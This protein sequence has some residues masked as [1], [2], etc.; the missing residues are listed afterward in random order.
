[1]KLGFILIFITTTIYSF[2]LQVDTIKDHEVKN[3]FVNND[4]TSVKIDSV[5]VLLLRSLS[6]QYQLKIGCR[7]GS[8]QELFYLYTYETVPGH[9]IETFHFTLEPDDT[10]KIHIEGFDYCIQCIGEDLKAVAPTPLVARMVFYTNTGIDSLIIEGTQTNIS[11]LHVSE[12]FRKQIITESEKK[13]SIF[14]IQGKKIGC[15]YIQIKHAAGIIV[16]KDKYARIV[17]L[18]LE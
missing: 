3:V 12:P 5:E 9:G 16:L 10:L 7:W 8:N 17:K 2:E 13:P 6:D 14:T 18:Q 4:S 15:N 11:Y 1:M